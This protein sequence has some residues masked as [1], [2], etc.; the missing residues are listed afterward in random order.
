MIVLRVTAI[1]FDAL[2]FL[3]RK[4]VNGNHMA[5]KDNKNPK[6]LAYR[7]NSNNQAMRRLRAELIQASAVSANAAVK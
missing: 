6:R 4:S 7:N 2:A 5:W 1:A 3:A